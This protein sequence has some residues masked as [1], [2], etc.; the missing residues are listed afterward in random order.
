MQL[1]DKQ[2]E[3]VEF[4]EGPCLVIAGAGSGKTRVLTQRIASLIKGGVS[5]YEILAITFTNKAAKEM[6]ERV[7]AIL[8]EDASKVFIGTFHSFG[9][10]VI[11]ENYEELGYS[12]NISIMDSN[13]VK[14]LVKRLMKDDGLDFESYDAKTFINAISYA[15]SEGISADEY[16]VNSTSSNT[17][18]IASVYKKYVNALMTNNSVDF[19]DLLILP[20]KLFKLNK[21]V[22]NKYQEHYKYLLVDEYQ[23]TNTSQYE[24]CRRLAKKYNNIFVVGDEDQCIYSWRNA[25]Y[26][27]ILNFEKDYK[28]AKVIMLE[29][30]YRSTS[31]ILGAAASVIKNNKIRKN[32][33]LFSSNEEGKKIKQVT[34]L[35]EKYEASFIATKVKELV[36]NNGYDYKDFGVLYRTNAQSRVIEEAFL[37]ENVPYKV[38]GSYYFYNRKEIKDLISY[39]SLIYNDK[40]D[41]SLERII[42]VPKRKIGF[43]TIDGIREN[44]INNNL[45]MFDAIEDGNPL[46]FRNI[47]NEL[48]EDA[49][50][51]SLTELVDAILLKSGIK[52]SLNT[53]TL[54]DEA[55]LLNLEEFKS[56][57]SS[58]EERGSITL[59]EFLENIMLVSDAGQYKE[60]KDAVNIM[61]L[62][63]AKGLEFRVV[64]IS[65]MEDGLFPSYRTLDIP[66][67]LEEERRLFYV[68]IT[69][70]REE[71]YLL[72]AKTR[73]IFGK[74]CNN[75]TSR[76]IREI[77]DIY[78]DLEPDKPITKGTSIFIS[79]END[80]EFKKGDI[81]MHNY[82]GKGVI[83]EMEG[84]V[85]SIAFGHGVGIKKIA[86]NKR[87]LKKQ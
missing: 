71:L 26:K 61:T 66:K 15:K 64:F 49:K 19:D 13:D 59:E 39:L 86:A 78:I 40:D 65:G 72:N 60:T 54:E 14:S 21:E 27:N 68:G 3:A 69:R 75:I 23:D 34:C 43:K 84:F 83:V 79:E 47:I 42:N 82:F 9:L 8:G 80:D 7:E 77:D 30:N 24:L 28:N 31:N 2:R 22:L 52:S 6:K 1:N 44:A 67:E 51:M 25:N 81:V 76:F 70:A 74:I 17:D 48:K 46:M 41:V 50:T 62:H 45:S 29:E 10:K 33:N 56:I 20:V 53:G 85:A 55:K 58:F 16:L 38:I 63:C 36:F 11:R 32:K 87:F 12:K 5:P 73:L 18:A 37:R 57:T 4:K 35:N